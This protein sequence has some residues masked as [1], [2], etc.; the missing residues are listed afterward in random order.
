LGERFNQAKPAYPA[1]KIYFCPER[2]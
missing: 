2:A 1:G